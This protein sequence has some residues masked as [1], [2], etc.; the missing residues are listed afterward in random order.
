MQRTLAGYV[1]QRLLQSL[2]TVIGIVLV[3]FVLIHIAPGDP[4]DILAGGLG[5]EPEYY[6]MMR[7]QFGLDRP[8]WA[9]ALSYFGQVARGNLGFSYMSREPVTELL[10]SRLPATLLLGLTAV[11]FA[12]VFGILIGVSQ[13]AR[14]NS[15]WDVM[16]VGI[17][18]GGYSIP[19]F[20]LGQILLLVFGVN[21]RWFPIGGIATAREQLTS[22]AAVLDTL[23]HLVLPAVTLG[24]FQ[25]A[26]IARL[27]RASVLEVI[28]QNYVVTARAK[29]LP[30]RVVYFKHVLR[31]ALPSVVTVIGMNVAFVFAG[32]VLTESVFA[33][34]GVGRLMYEALLSR[35]YPL[36]SGIFLFVS[37]AVVIGNL[38][39]DV[40]YAILDPRISFR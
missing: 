18:V 14:P 33:W 24:V 3:A 35:D 22:W 10:L 7:A 38:V 21:L 32:S 25:M 11:L 1:T 20:W 6:E 28:W 30:E 40:T 34:P 15:L 36:L 16:A 19:L 26:L 23:H 5:A 12:T 17:S 8:I 13:A 39:T 2:P 29:G 31:N 27:T 9:R 37:A 4:V